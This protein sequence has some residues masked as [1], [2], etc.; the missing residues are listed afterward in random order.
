MSKTRIEKISNY[1][2]EELQEYFNKEKLSILHEIKLYVDDM[3]H[4]QGKETGFKDYQYD[5]LKE[6]LQIRDPNYIVPIGAKIREGQ[7]RVKLP[8][9]LGSM[10]K[11]KPEDKK[12]IEKWMIKNKSSEYIIEDKLD[13]VSCLVIINKGKIKLYTRGDGIIGADISYLSQYFDSIPKDLNIDINIR[14]EL[15]MP[16]DIFNKKYSNEYANPRNMVAGRIGAKKIKEGLK[17]IK[18]IA[19]EIVG[20]ELMNKPTEQLKYLNSLGFTTVRYEIINNITI[21]N[22]IEILLK[23]KKNN[24][25]EIDGIIIQPNNKYIRNIDGNPDYAFA[26]KMRLNENIVETKVVD[27]IW[28]VSKWGLLKPRIEVKPVN[29]GGVKITYTTGFNAK[30][31]YNNNIGEGTIIKVTRSGDVIPYIVEVIKEAKEPDMPIINWEWNKTGVDI[32]TNEMDNLMCIKLLHSFF[33][34]LNIKQLG[35]KRIGKL[36]IGGLDTLLKIIGATETEMCNIEGIGNKVGKTIYQNIRKNM[37]NLY[38]PDVL[39]A[40]GIF[41]FGMGKKRISKLFDDIPNILDLSTK[42]TKKELYNKIIQIEGFS[43]ITTKNIVDNIS[44]AN[45]F[46]D[47]FSNFATFKQKV[48]INNNMNG[49]KIIFSGFRDVQLSEKVIERGGKIVTSISKN[50]NILV[51]S[52]KSGKETDKVKKAKE[53]NIEILDKEEFIEKYIANN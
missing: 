30:Y 1:S 2:E 35:E 27:V 6:T 26:F 45:K 36:Y 19:Y 4:N 24:I 53:F 12:E 15:I 31:I 39:G 17:D 18:F 43:D 8:F 3:Y 13:G 7:N 23:F 51:V 14:G 29:L 11:F 52:N 21:D 47:E 16:I 44:W 20:N 33:E 48:I 49:L 42:I 28:N 10:D 22:L 9:W 37:E 41:G 50:T 46:I 40:S 5:M 25:F 38:I 32:I 34:K